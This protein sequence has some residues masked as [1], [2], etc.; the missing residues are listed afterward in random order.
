MEESQK[1]LCHPEFIS[2]SRNQTISNASIG[3]I[4]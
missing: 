4:S 2:G 1:L 3:D